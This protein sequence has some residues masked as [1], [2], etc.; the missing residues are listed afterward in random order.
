[1]GFPSNLYLLLEHPE[2]LLIN[3]DKSDTN[4]QKINNISQEISITPESSFLHPDVSW[5]DLIFS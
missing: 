1:M 4:D 5:E 3:P 2:I